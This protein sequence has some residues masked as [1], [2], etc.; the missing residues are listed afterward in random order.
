[1]EWKI[2]EYLHSGKRLRVLFL[3][4]VGF[5]YGAGIAQMRQIQSFLLMGCEVAGLCW[6]H[7]VEAQI[8]FIPHDASGTWLGLR[9]M[10]HLHRS[11]GSDDEMI[12]KGL[13][14]EIYDISP[15]LIVVGN[16]HGARWPLELLSVLREQ[17][18]PMVVYMH[19]LFWLSGRC[20][21]SGECLKFISGCDATC[22][23]AHEYPELEPSKI[24]NAWKLRRS[25]FCG[26]D[27][28]PLATNSDWIT[29]LAHDALA[30]TTKSETIYLGLDTCFYRPIDKKLARRLL[31]LSQDEFII[32]SGAVNVYEN[33]KGVKYLQEIIHYL[34]S[35]ATFIVFGENSLTMDGVYSSGLLRDYRKMILLYN[36]A[37]VFIGTALQEAFGQTF[38]EAS[39][40]EL[41]VVAFN[42]GGVSEVI[43][44]AQTGILV[45]PGDN[46]EMIK[47]IG[48]LRNDRAFR[49]VLGRAGRQRIE[50]KFSLEKQK[51]RWVNFL[52]NIN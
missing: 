2:G 16:L 38:C 28:I 22:P 51:E 45:P 6:S 50:E 48:T 10:P 20:A 9:Q 52:L 11:R 43:T 19:D 14:E 36:A 3:N 5:Q 17:G 44:D 23:T 18:I 46:K 15:D 39:A 49:V 27:G 8:P 41:P 7:G 25:L 35:S 40:C 42:I 32:L 21:Y 47:A 24:E 12:I 33:R 30:P 37:D 34:H 1:M 13:L 26:P 4:D 31:R 29:R